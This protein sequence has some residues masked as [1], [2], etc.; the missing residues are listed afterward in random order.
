MN[1]KIIYLGAII[2]IT[3]SVCFYFLEFGFY[4]IDEE[5]YTYITKSLVNNRQFHFETDY[6]KTQSQQHRIHFSV[7]SQSRVYSVFPPGYPFLAAPFYFVFGIKGMQLA[8]IFF[9]LS[10]MI[11]MFFFV[12]DFYGEKEAA[13]TTIVLLGSTQIL[14]YSV[15]LWSHI[16]A[17]F[18]ILLSFYLLFT[19]RDLMAAIAL[20]FGIG[21]RYS[22][23]V[24]VPAMIYYLFFKRKKIIPLFIIGLLIGLTPMFFYNNIS[25]GS[26]WVNG[27]SILNSEEGYK[28]LNLLQIPKGVITNV[29]HYNF[30]PE[31]EF[32][33]NKSSLLETSPFFAFAFLGGY[34]FW[35]EKKELKNEF[36]TLVVSIALFV[37][38]ISGTWSFGG[39]AHNMR[40]LTDIIPLIVFFSLV[41]LF[42]LKLDYSKFLVMVLGVVGL[43][44]LSGISHTWLRFYS[45]SLAMISLILILNIILLGIDFSKN[46]LKNV[47]IIVF[48]ISIGMSVFTAANFTNME[49]LNRKSVMT[50]AN[51]FEQTVPEG[52]VVFVIGGEYVTY[53]EK[54]YIFLDYRHAPNDI[55]HL[56]SFYKDKPLFVLFKDETDKEKF[57]NFWLI[58]L[59]PTRTF[60]ILSKA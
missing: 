30:F 44:Y 36:Y 51:M 38:F 7:I 45:V 18:L 46:L 20:G 41:P 52:S 4:S 60:K 40:L 33:Y 37:L 25:F 22:S 29:F 5:S 28:A 27:M 16:P 11:T 50:A 3:L 35:K 6:P 43:F 48:A 17:A 49:Q 14:N 19:G 1:R 23:L 55:S 10:M 32:S 53:T 54:D 34:L 31:L 56:V 21:V 13:I 47:I 42:H 57:N 9:T 24:I 26:P 2:I 8:N 15:S 39:L 58:P 12:N 59:D